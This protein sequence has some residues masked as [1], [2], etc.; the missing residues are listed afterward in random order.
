MAPIPGLGSATRSG[1]SPWH[2]R[3]AVE[4]GQVDAYKAHAASE[5]EIH[6]TSQ[7]A[8]AERIDLQCARDCAGRCIPVETS[9]LVITQQLLT[10]EALGITPDRIKAGSDVADQIPGLS[11]Q[12]ACGMDEQQ[13]GLLAACAPEPGVLKPATGSFSDSPSPVFTTQR[14]RSSMDSGV[15]TLA[16][17]MRRICIVAPQLFHS[18]TTSSRPPA[19]Y[20]YTPAHHTSITVH[21][22]A[23]WDSPDSPPRSAA[24]AAKPNPCPPSGSPPATPDCPIRSPR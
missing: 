12:Q 14:G 19:E 21:P 13:I 3:Q 23:C 11:N 15:K 4:R 22:S 8:E 9:L 18:H 10:T 7:I 16:H 1:C 24:G 6:L 5:V 17:Q 20:S 2:W